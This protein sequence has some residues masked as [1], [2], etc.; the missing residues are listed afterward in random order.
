MVWINSHFLALIGQIEQANAVHVM[1][2]HIWG[3][4]GNLKNLVN[5]VQNRTSYIN[6]YKNELVFY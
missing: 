2:S 4:F 3:V 6:W 5:M 1:L